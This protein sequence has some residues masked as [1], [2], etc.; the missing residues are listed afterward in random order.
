LKQENT[1]LKF[2]LAAVKK[3]ALRTDLFVKPENLLI[4]GILK[5]EN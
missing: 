2:A 4:H 3:M 5:K 1:G